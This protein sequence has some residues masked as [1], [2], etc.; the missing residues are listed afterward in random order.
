MIYRDMKFLLSPNPKYYL[1]LMCVIKSMANTSLRVTDTV[2]QASLRP[3]K[4]TGV[5]MNVGQACNNKP[6][7]IDELLLVIHM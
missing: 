5:F 2:C 1:P 7:Y 4:A 6:Q 3:F